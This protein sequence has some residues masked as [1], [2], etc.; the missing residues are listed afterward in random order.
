MYV[1]KQEE[2]IAC[3]CLLLA[4]LMSVNTER[5]RYASAVLRVVILSVRPSVCPSVCHMRT[6]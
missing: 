3:S 5:R 1:E 2:A 6:L 4:V